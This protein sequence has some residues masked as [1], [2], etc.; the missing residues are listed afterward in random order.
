MVDEVTR[1]ADGDE[2]TQHTSPLGYRPSSHT[3]TPAFPVSPPAGQQPPAQR[4]PQ[5]YSSAQF[6]PQRFPPPPPP[7]KKKRGRGLELAAVGVVVLIALGIGVA[8]AV[9]KNG[10]PTASPSPTRQPANVSCEHGQLPNGACAEVAGDSGQ[11]LNDHDFL[12]DAHSYL[13]SSDVSDEKLIELA[14]A[15]CTALDSNG[16]DVAQIVNV[17]TTVP[18]KTLLLLVRDAALYYCPQWKNQTLAYQLPT[19]IEDGNWLPGTDFPAGTY[20]TTTQAEDCYWDVTTGD[21]DKKHYVEQEIG[22]GHYKV[23][24]KAGQKFKTQ[25]CGTWK[26]VG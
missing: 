5:E 9:A 12:V 24:L 3:P 14:K 10:T 18:K 8:W 4:G 26:K 13:P 11:S 1:P 22:P 2:P 25:G 7:R 20:E 23:K 17:D 16:G 21:G 15:M 19:G 6:V